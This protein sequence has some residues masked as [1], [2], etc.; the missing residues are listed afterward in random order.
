[1]V[2]EF[3]IGGTFVRYITIKCGL[4]LI[5]VGPFN[6]SIPVIFSIIDIFFIVKGEI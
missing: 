2:Q 5:L 4:G 1:L 3:E 6:L